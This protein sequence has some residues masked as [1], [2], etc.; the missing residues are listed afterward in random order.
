[1]DHV[2]FHGLGGRGLKLWFWG[3]SGGPDPNFHS[4]VTSEQSMSDRVQSLHLF[5]VVEICSHALES[6]GS[7][8]SC[9][10][11]GLDAAV[12]K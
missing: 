10:S 5:R 1:M 8:G 12:M 9:D 4:K 6:F 2:D 11:L 3:C 7:V